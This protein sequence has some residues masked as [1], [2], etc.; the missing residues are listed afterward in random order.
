M[1]VKEIRQPNF[2]VS[3][4]TVIFDLRGQRSSKKKVVQLIKEITDKEGI[5]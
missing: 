5:A 1:M 3:E 2:G 4:A